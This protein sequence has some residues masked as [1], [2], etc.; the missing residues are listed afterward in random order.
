MPYCGARSLSDARRGPAR[1][2][3]GASAGNQRPGGRT[4]AGSRWK[5][6]TWSWSRRASDGV[7]GDLTNRRPSCLA[8]GEATIRDGS[9]SSWPASPKATRD[10]SLLVAIAHGKGFAVR[11][12]TDLSGPLDEPLRLPAEQPVEVRLV[13]LEGTPIAG[14]E[15]RP[16][17]FYPSQG[18]PG[19]G[20]RIPVP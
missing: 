9:G 10:G 14:A 13:N 18:R 5:G 16:H 11:E 8:A 6:L 3:G 1:G 4:R 2:L 12:L 15:V 20:R 7:T 19:P 17:A